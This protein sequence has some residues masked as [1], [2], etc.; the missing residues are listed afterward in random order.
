MADL[1]AITA[2]A[3]VEYA[4]FT[5]GAKRMVVRGDM[6]SVNIDIDKAKDSAQNGYRWSG[7]TH[8]GYDLFALTASDG[9][10]YV[11]K[12]FGQKR[13]VFIIP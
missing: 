11:L 8:P 7:H 3:G 6:G 5:K 10:Y 4:L 1:S 12:A 9:D 13:A 2:E